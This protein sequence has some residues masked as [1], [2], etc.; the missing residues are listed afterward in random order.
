MAQFNYNHLH[1]FWVV[2]RTGSI[3]KAAEQLFLTPQTISGQIR[4]LEDSIGARLFV[5]SGRNLVLTDTGRLV[6]QYADDM[7]QLGSELRDVL[8]G[9]QPDGRQLFTVGIADVVPKL[10]AYRI[11][12]P[13]LNLPIRLV[14][15]EGK[16]ES[17]L[18]DLAIHKLDLVLADTPLPPSMSLKAFSHLLGSSGLSFF[19]A[20]QC[21]DEIRGPFPHC[22]QGAPLLLPTANNALRRAMDLWFETEGIQPAVVGEFE[23]GAL[24]MAF[25]QAGAGIY[26]APTAIEDEI[27][28]QYRARCI[29]RTEAITESFYAISAERR[30]KHPAVLA[31]SDRAR[32]AL[33]GKSE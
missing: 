29:G 22:L 13:A 21:A 14:C 30:L 25:G 5:R 24:M 1:Y 19:V 3:A 28:R 31:I 4:T 10:I 11:L 27:Q 6:Y 20:P 23:D 2:A 26:T 9:A 17:L 7:F 16:L 15:Q 8:K 18:A 12:E 33:F 32:E